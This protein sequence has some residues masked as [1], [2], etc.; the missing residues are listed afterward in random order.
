[1]G[2]LIINREEKDSFIIKDTLT[3]KTIVVTTEEISRKGKRVK[4]SINADEQFHILRSEL[5]DPSQVKELNVAKN[6]KTQNVESL[7]RPEPFRFSRQTR[8]KR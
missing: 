1:M 4:L 6:K 8:H 3:G 5:L 7:P 2:H